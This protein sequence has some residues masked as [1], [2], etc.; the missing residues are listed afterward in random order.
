MNSIDRYVFR[1]S[2]GAF[3]LVL[4]SLTVVIW[5]TQI[6]RE[7]DL[8]TGQGQTILVFLG[9]TSLLIPILMLIMAPLSMAIAVAYTLIKL[10]SDS[11]LVV[12]SA[13]GISP[14]RLF[15]PFL[16]LAILVALMVGFLSAYLAPKLQRVMT[17]QISRVRADVVANIVRPGSFTT[18]ERGLTVHLRERWGDDQFAGILIDDFRDP[19]ERMTILA[20]YGHIVETE[21]GP[22]L[23]M[24]NGNVQRRR[25]HERDPTFVQ[26][27]RYP[28]DLSPFT[29]SSQIAF[30]LREKFLWDLASPDPDDPLLKKVPAQFRAE[31]HDRIVAPLYPLAFLVIAFAILGTPRTTRQGRALSTIMVLTGVAALRLFGFACVTIG[32]HVP[33]ALVTIYPAIALTIGLGMYAIVRG[34]G[35]E[36]ENKIDLLAIRDRALAKIS[37]AAVRQ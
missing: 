15:R 19:N 29:V 2:F 35:L 32:L 11:E 20:D 28:F 7:I 24:M 33:L 6:L 13:A 26:F 10:N 14:W 9:I 22:F 8:I 3:L 1:T 21:R 37:T 25:I 30:G 31:F 12:M 17:E 23:V 18:I 4:V 34:I 5:L 27:E 36:F 16:W